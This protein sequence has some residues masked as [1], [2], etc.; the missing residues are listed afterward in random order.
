MAVTYPEY[1]SLPGE[2]RFSSD[3]AGLC[4]SSLQYEYLGWGEIKK[5][6]RW[7]FIK[8]Q[9]LFSSKTEVWGS[10]CCQRSQAISLPP[11]LS[12]S[13]SSATGHY[14]KSPLLV[15]G[16]TALPSLP[17]HTYPLIFLKIFFTPNSKLSEVTS[18][19]AN[20]VI[21]LEV[22]PASAEAVRR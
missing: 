13:F 11:P 18:G 17:L 1:D 9:R 21:L 20:K 19:S 14:E 2:V 7:I 4:S 10:V 8:A 15:G 6:E 3:R 12:H 16:H 22:C 5:R